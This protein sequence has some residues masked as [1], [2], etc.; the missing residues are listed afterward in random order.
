MYI[1]V[2]SNL[3]IPYIITTRVHHTALNFGLDAKPRFVILVFVLCCRTIKLN[4]H[5]FHLGTK[6]TLPNQCNT[7]KS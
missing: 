3:F 6:I 4:L 1:F 7:V 5:L 2:Y